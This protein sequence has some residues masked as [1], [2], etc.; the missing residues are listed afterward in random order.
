MN[1]RPDPEPVSDSTRPHSPRAD[2]ASADHRKDA[3]ALW[4]LLGE[5]A[6]TPA[7][8]DLSSRILREVRLSERPQKSA[9]S[10]WV[11]L[12]GGLGLAGSAAAVVLALGPAGTGGPAPSPAAAPRIV[13][14]HADFPAGEAVLVADV[15]PLE[16]EE[17]YPEELD[18]YLEAEMLLAST[19][20][21]PAAQGLAW[22]GGF[23]WLVE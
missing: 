12:A 17:V 23:D 18:E 14:A 4:D 11:W 1:L 22:D 3:D 5:R 8:G 19:T 6:V 16:P 2:L 10:A 13:G 20:V 7:P 9:P 21:D 15:E